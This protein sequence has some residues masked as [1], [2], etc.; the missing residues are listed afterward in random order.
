M[1]EFT[2]E[3]G[4]R[5]PLSSTSLTGL[6]SCNHTT[7]SQLCSVLSHW[8]YCLPVADLSRNRCWC[9]VLERQ[10]PLVHCTQCEPRWIWILLDQRKYTV[11][12]DTYHMYSISA[13]HDPSFSSLFAFIHLRIA[14]G[15]KLGS[16]MVDASGL[17]QIAILTTSG[18][19]SI[20]SSFFLLSH[21]P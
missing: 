21:T 1:L 15:A 10:L 13:L 7:S 14:C 18:E 8:N 9:Q 20:A 3:N 19:V 4:L 5:M 2:Q 12:Q 11:S 6:V 16:H 17:I